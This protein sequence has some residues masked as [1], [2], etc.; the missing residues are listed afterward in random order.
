M[1]CPYSHDQP[2]GY[3]SPGQY[4]LTVTS[5]YYQAGYTAWVQADQFQGGFTV[6]PE[7]GA[8]LP[9]LATGL[10]TLPRRKRTTT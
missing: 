1:I 7:P 5:Y 10:V 6:L 4:S 8:M 2:V 9:L 3:L